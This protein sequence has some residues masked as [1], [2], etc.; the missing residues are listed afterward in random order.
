[1]NKKRIEFL[2]KKVKDHKIRVLDMCLENGGHISSSFSS[3]EILVY[4]YYQE[5][6]STNGNRFVISKGHGEVLYFSLLS[7]L[8]YF[9]SSWLKKSYRKNDCKLG[10]H[11]SSKIPGIEFSA[12]SLGH[13]LS[14]SAGVAFALKKKK[15]DKKKI[16]CL[17]GDAELNEGSVWEAVIFA[18]K[19]N[20]SNLVAMVDYN[21]IGSS[22]FLKNYISSKPLALAWEKLGW[23]VNY[24]D[25]H[26]FLTIDKTIKKILSKK[27][28][29]P[30][31]I[32]FDTIKGKGISFM[33]NDPIWHVKG[34]DGK[35]YDLALKELKGDN[36]S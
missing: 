16:F 33:E 7:D 26:N 11:V 13:G 3:A 31:V 12:G 29:K 27:G 22:D 5:I 20:L 30:N 15:I 18:S 23:K 32:I 36:A 34:L 10:G 25:G 6:I 24:V 9:P 1:M 4:L 35:L 8:G 21:K 17:L 2:K 14:Y 19:N 28:S